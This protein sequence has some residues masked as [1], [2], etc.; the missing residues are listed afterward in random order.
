[1]KSA[2]IKFPHSYEVLV[3]DKLLNAG[4]ASNCFL[5]LIHNQKDMFI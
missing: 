3:V 2:Q 5:S 1:M 4:V